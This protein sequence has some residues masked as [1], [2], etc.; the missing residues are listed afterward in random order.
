MDT[1]LLSLHF[2]ATKF[3]LREMMGR[4]HI[5]LALWVSRI[6]ISKFFIFIYV[7]WCFACRYICVKVSG[8]LELELQTVLSCLWVLRIESESFGRTTSAL[9]C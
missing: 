9:N 8:P 7:R 5:I 4:L 1:F 6:P 3:W 2:Q